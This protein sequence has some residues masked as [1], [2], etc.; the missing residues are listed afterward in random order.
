[1]N[2][3]NIV[4]GGFLT[5]R[6][7]KKLKSRDSRTDKLENKRLLKDKIDKLSVNGKVAIVY[8]GVDCDYSRWDNRV[9]FVNANVTSVNGWGNDYMEYAEGSQWYDIEPMD[10]ALSLKETSRDLIMEAFENG[11][12]HVIYV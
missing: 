2:N 6:E 3:R 9:A 11:H 5:R 1:M 7:I 8:G 4:V 12:P 10:Y